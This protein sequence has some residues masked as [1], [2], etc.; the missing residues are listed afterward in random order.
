MCASR[1]ILEG[2]REAHLQLAP[3]PPRCRAISS[4]F[5]TLPARYRLSSRL[6]MA[7][8][9]HHLTMPPLDLP[10]PPD[11]PALPLDL[12]LYPT[13]M[14]F[15]PHPS[16]SPPPQIWWVSRGGRKTVVAWNPPAA[17]NGRL[18]RRARSHPRA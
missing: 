7:W 16:A 15:S 3:P 10:P 12:L 11:L 17:T 5:F 8:G 6:L 9:S 1:S 14:D 4:K 2:P 18:L 13:V